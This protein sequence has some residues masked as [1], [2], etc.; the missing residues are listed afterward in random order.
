MYLGLVDAGSS[1]RFTVPAGTVD[2]GVQGVNGGSVIG[3][4]SFRANA[5]VPY[6][7]NLGRM[8]PS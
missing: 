8:T 5:D 7:I 2:I 1:A 6:T 4:G 3:V